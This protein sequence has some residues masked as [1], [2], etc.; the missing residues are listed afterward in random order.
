MFCATLEER[1]VDNHKLSSKI[2]KVWT[3]S[4]GGE[5]LVQEVCKHSLAGR[6]CDVRGVIEE[7]Y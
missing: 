7:I 3:A 5:F 2:R 1:A 4:C 6:S